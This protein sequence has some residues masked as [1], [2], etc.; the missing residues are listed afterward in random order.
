MALCDHDDVAKRI[1]TSSSYNHWFYVCLVVLFPLSAAWFVI[2]VCLYPM[3]AGTEMS[4]VQTKD[5][6]AH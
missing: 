6:K 4:E 5:R 2:Q 1:G 3:S